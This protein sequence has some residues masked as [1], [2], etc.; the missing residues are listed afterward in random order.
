MFKIDE[1]SSDT[2]A[3]SNV[4]FFCFD[5]CWHVFSSFSKHFGFIGSGIFSFSNNLTKCFGD[6]A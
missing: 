4:Y 1:L 2:G 5:S 3:T 6:F